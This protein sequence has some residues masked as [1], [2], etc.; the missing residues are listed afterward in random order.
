MFFIFVI[1]AVCFC[2][3]LPKQSVFG[4]E[5]VKAIS[6]VADVQ[7]V[8]NLGLE[9]TPNGG[10]AIVEV[11]PA[12]AQEFYNSLHPKCIVMT[13]ECDQMNNLKNYL[14][15]TNFYTQSLQDKTI[16][17]GYTS[18]FDKCEFIE[19]K[20]INVQIVLDDNQILVGFPLIM[21]GF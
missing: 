11:E 15:M 20:K 4:I 3:F 8:Q 21:T 7:S 13:L 17:Y 14:N 1:F 19:G 5:N 6:F 12:S 2:S 10:D 16:V 18:K 9:Y